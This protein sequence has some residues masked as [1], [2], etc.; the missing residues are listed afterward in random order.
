MSAQT[1]S[2][3]LVE[4][5]LEY[6]DET[7]GSC[8]HLQV[9]DVVLTPEGPKPCWEF[10]RIKNKGKG[11]ADSRR[12]RHREVYF[13]ALLPVG[14]WIRRWYK[15]H[16]SCNRGRWEQGF[17]FYRVGPEGPEPVDEEEVP[18]EVKQAFKLRK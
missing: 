17:L 5:E 13:R 14:T 11:Y 3:S 6:R 12:N 18:E 9:V 15:N 4:V 2:T 1:A 10:E 7:W 16:P 8:R